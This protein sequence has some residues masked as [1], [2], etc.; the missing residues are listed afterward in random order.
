MSRASAC[1]ATGSHAGTAVGVGPR[2]GGGL[3]CAGA[4]ARQRRRGHRRPQR[5]AVRATSRANASSR[6]SSDG[7]GSACVV[8]VAGSARSHTG[9]HR[10]V[11]TGAHT[12]AHTG[13]HTSSTPSR[14]TR[15][16]E[17]QERP[18][19]RHARETAAS[20][21]PDHTRRPV[22]RDPFAAA[23]GTSGVPAAPPALAPSAF[24]PWASVG[25]ASRRDR[26]DVRATAAAAT[27]DAR[28]TPG[29]EAHLG[30]AHRA[31]HPNACA[32]ERAQADVEHRTSVIW[33]SSAV[34]TGARPGRPPTS[35]ASRQ[36]PGRC[37]RHGPDPREQTAH[38]RSEW[39]AGRA[40]E[41][42]P[43]TRSCRASSGGRRR[44]GG[45]R[46]ADAG[47]WS[48]SGSRQEQRARTGRGRRAPRRRRVA[49]PRGAA[50]VAAA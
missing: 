44:P 26:P 47:A 21:S 9:V 16:P 3:A 30:R 27:I 46:S 12:G 38:R 33:R 35:R 42:P 19:P 8:S 32:R 6:G 24:T 34:A 22:R 2:P 29:E 45:A 31:G 5:P 1:G 13:P 15:S 39:A 7:A 18:P 25:R 48:S 36:P 17:A 40:V 11:H 41:A 14:F 28:C 50:R 49:A 20:A 43:R 37:G 23:A 4:P 10:G